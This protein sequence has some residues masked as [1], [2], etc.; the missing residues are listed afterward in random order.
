MTSDAPVHVQS[1]FLVHER[2]LVYAT[3]AGG[4]TDAFVDVDT[5]IEVYKIRQVVDAG[6]FQ[7]FTA[8][9][10]GSHGLQDFGIRPDLRVTAHADFGGGDSGEGR[11]LNRSVAI[12]AID[13]IVG[14]MV[15]VTEGYWLR[16]DD[17]NVGNVSAAVH[18]VGEGD[19]SAGSKYSARKAY[20]G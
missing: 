5:V 17:F 4:A 3:V 10:T 14:H 7:R 15:L 18:G 13:A 9:V 12:A 2:H 16:F 8:A 20:F 6:P 11:R 1:V 19:E